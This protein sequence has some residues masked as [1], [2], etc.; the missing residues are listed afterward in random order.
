MV[1]FYLSFYRFMKSIYYLT[2]SSFCMGVKRSISELEKIIQNHPG[3]QIFCVHELVHNPKVNAY[4][5]SKGVVFVENF[6][7]IE[8]WKHWKMENDGV[9]NSPYSI[10]HFLLNKVICFSAHGTNRRI[11]LEAKKK[12]K[13][14]YNLECP[15]VTK[16]Y[17]EVDKFVDEWIN[18]FVYIGKA[19]HQEW[20]NVVEYIK[21][22]WNNIE[23]FEN[24]ENLKNKFNSDQKFAVLSQTT[25]NYQFVIDTLDQIKSEFPNAQIPVASDVCKATFDRQNAIIDNLDKF[26]T[27]IVIWW[28]DSN[29]TKELYNIGVK[30]QKKSFFVEDLEDLK[31]NFE[32]D[33]FSNDKIAI[34]GGAS[35]PEEDIREVFN[36]YVK[37]WYNPFVTN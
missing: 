27:L 22:L 10:L 24:I 3:D 14:V 31:N 18:D 4:F 32:S 11:I 34:T 1:L 20:K 26:D 21:Y 37:K 36:H 8:I 13:Y 15:L 6:D 7:E 19:N 5:R 33:L 25:L 35:T 23:I 12:Y 17:N 28:K 29:N 16:I 9:N 2:P 30:N